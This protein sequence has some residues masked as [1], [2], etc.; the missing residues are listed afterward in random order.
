MVITNQGYH[1]IISADTRRTRIKIYISFGNTS[2]TITEDDIVANSLVYDTSCIDNG[3]FVI[4]STYATRCRF[5]VFKDYNIQDIIGGFF[6]VFFQIGSYGL[7]I[8]RYTITEATQEKG[9]IS[10]VGYDK[11]INGNEFTESEVQHRTDYIYSIYSDMLLYHDLPSISTSGESSSYMRDC[12]P[13]LNGNAIKVYY[14]VLDYNSPREIISEA[15]SLCGGFISQHRYYYNDVVHFSY[16]NAAFKRFG[17]TTATLSADLIRS[18]KVSSFNVSYD[19]LILWVDD[20][21]YSAGNPNGNNVYQLSIKLLRHNTD[22]ERQACAD[23][24]WTNIFQNLTYTPCEVE[25]FGDPAIEVGDKIII[26]YKN[27]TITSYVTDIEWKS[28]GIQTLK[29]GGDLIMSKNTESVGEKKNRTTNNAINEKFRVDNY[30]NS[31]AIALNVSSYNPFAVNYVDILETNEIN[32]T[33]ENIFMF[34]GNI[35]VDF[36]DDGLLFVKI[37]SR[38]DSSSTY[39]FDSY[40]VKYKVSA[41]Q[42]TINIFQNIDLNYRDGWNKVKI[43][44]AVKGTGTASVTGVNILQIGNRY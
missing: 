14:N 27:T 41:G 19:G 37:G 23:Y 20:T 29:C 12:A 2:E 9:F 10:L 17:T 16:Q 44:M 31:T 8:G 21:S 40:I 1:D 26:P 43:Q 32:I 25:Y 24:L 34:E 39:T 35:D 36:S 38:K 13:T 7:E 3:K 5:S 28:R 15:A 4:G 6:N 30:R 33:K 11:L 22:A 18:L 42:Q